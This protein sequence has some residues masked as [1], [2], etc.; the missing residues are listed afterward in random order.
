M[1]N[2]EVENRK[3]TVKQPIEVVLT[4]DE[5]QHLTFLFKS[6]VNSMG[7]IAAG[8]IILDLANCNFEHINIF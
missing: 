6:E 4:N 1:A 2:W 7:R 3:F 8:I 5:A